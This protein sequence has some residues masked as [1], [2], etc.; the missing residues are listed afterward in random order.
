[1]SKKDWLSA[2]EAAEYIGV[3]KPQIFRLINE[4]KIIASLNTEAPV[5]YYLIDRTSLENYKKTPKNKG[6][7]PRQKGK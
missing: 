6:G 7:R 5:P 4:K 3:T 2:R 1:M